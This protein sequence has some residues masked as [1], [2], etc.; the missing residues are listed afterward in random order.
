MKRNTIQLRVK[1]SSKAYLEYMAEDN[2]SGY[3]R[4]LIYSDMMKTNAG[5]LMLKI[6]EVVTDIEERMMELE[7]TEL[8]LAGDKEEHLE[9]FKFR[10]D[11]LTM[12]FDIS[13][14]N[15]P[16]EQMINLFNDI[17]KTQDHDGITVFDI[18]YSDEEL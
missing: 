5:K 15:V 13:R 14:G 9:L 18:P 17:C 16:E 6:D 12:Q 3:I 2:I 1:K 10:V 8:E 11:I 7:E 4:Q